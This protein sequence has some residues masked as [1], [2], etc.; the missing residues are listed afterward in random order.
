MWR[1]AGHW[2][3]IHSLPSCR[4]PGGLS[5]HRAHAPSLACPPSP[6]SSCSVCPA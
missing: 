2:G 1:L 3:C 4:Q 6:R 5:S